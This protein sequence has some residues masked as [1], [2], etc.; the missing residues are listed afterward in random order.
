VCHAACGD[1][2]PFRP[3][4]YSNVR[5]HN[6]RPPSSSFPSSVSVPLTAKEAHEGFRRDCAST[7]RAAATRRPGV[8]L[9]VY[10]PNAAWLETS[11]RTNLT[12]PSHHRD[13]AACN[14]VHHPYMVAATCIYWSREGW[15]C[16]P[17]IRDTLWLAI[18]PLKAQYNCS[19]SW[20]TGVTLRR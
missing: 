15:L 4:H 16:V 3:R 20:T 14:A 1:V 7:H 17:R 12:P 11:P 2:Q 6:A 18:L 13:H 8:S 9:L 10:D 19:S 5:A